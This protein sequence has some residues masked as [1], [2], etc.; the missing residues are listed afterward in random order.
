M[1]EK[2]LYKISLSGFNSVPPDKKDKLKE[3]LKL[4]LNISDEKALDLMHKKEL[5]IGR[6]LSRGKAS[7][8]GKKFM[9]TGL[10]VKL[11]RSKSSKE[12]AK[13]KANDL[14]AKDEQTILLNQPIFFDKLI[15]KKDE[16]IENL[17]LKGIQK[18][19][20]ISDWFKLDFATWV[21]IIFLFVVG[22]GFL[23]YLIFRY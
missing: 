2:L 20:K 9:A 18:Q 11:I 7:Y 3:F 21:L 8:L 12:N 5:I 1:E 17:E 23:L 6:G 15:E 22:A 16:K 19:K 4:H 13:E 10:K 14:K